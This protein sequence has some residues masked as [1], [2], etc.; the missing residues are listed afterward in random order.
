MKDDRLYECIERIALYADEGK[1]VFFA[2]TRTQDAVMRNLQTLS[3]SMQRISSSLRMNHAEVDWRSV[4]AFRNVAVHDY[5][6]IDLKQIWDIVERDLPDL[7]RKIE[8][9]LEGLGGPA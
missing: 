5:L 7:K 6:G 3:E 4:A 8:T 9:I 2:D 1:S